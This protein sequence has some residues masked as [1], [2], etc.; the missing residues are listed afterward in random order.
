MTHTSRP[1]PTVVQKGSQIFLFAE[2]EWYTY[3]SAQ[4]PLGKGAMG[5]VYLGYSCNS[6]ENKVAVKRIKDEYANIPSIRQRA[7]TEASL[8]FR[9]NNL[10]EMIG[11]CETD[12]TTGPIFIISRFVRGIT[13]EQHVRS[14][15]S[16]LP[17]K[18]Y[19]ICESLFPIFDALDYLHSK[20]IIHMD[21]KPSNIMVEAG[22]NVR[23]MDLGIAYTPDTG[24]LSIGLVGT[25]HYAAPEQFVKEEEGPQT[26]I[27]QTTDIYELGVTLYEL[28]TGNNP[29]DAETREQILHKQQTLDLPFT[30]LLP[31]S[32]FKVLRKATAKKQQDRYQSV[33]EFK[34]SLQQALLHSRQ[35]RPGNLL[36]IIIG[37]ALG[38]ILTFIV[39]I[40][41]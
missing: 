29:F 23:L 19:R 22:C 37:V 21:I 30:Q 7:K 25:P 15:L 5:I 33:R 32:V 27:N 13:F 20:G 31:E 3:D 24:N 28:L 16:A 40:F 39:F 26:T 9:H 17:D 6:P 18:T 10:I 34:L 4:V 8:L 36:P 12:E 2:H 35:R 1:Y 11:Y 41:V 38:L 14:H